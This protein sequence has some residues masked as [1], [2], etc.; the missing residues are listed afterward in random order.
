M[1]DKDIIDANVTKE[2]EI[3]EQ[4]AL[5]VQGN[6]NS[7]T[8]FILAMIGLNFLAASYLSIVSLVLSIVSLAILAKPEKADRKPFTVFN[9]IS[10]PVAIVCI[11]LSTIIF[12][13]AVISGSTVIDRIIESIRAAMEEIS[14]S[15][16]I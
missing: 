1:E 6:K 8:A 14:T 13:I 2:E 15:A 9:R 10:K 3:K 12:I 4:R 5:D 16:S 11:V 7:L